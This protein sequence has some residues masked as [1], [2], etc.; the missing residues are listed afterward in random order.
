MSLALRCRAK[1]RKTAQLE[2]FMTRKKKTRRI[3]AARGRQ[4]RFHCHRLG[5]VLCA[6]D[7]MQGAAGVGGPTYA[8]ASNEPSSINAAIYSTTTM[9]CK[10][11]TLMTKTATRRAGAKWI[12]QV[13]PDKMRL[14]LCVNPDVGQHEECGDDHGNT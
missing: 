9:G 10:I 3:T 5:L 1:P 12:R 4:N 6:G 13:L 7:E 14:P 2:R 11:S 8:I